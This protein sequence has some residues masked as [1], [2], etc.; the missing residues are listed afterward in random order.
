MLFLIFLVPIAILGAV[1]AWMCWRARQRQIAV[2]MASISLVCTGL[3][4]GIVIAGLFFYE[5]LQTPLAG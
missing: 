1:V 5:A 3:S 4:V 2:I